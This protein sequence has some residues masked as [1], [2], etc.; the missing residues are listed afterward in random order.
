L[1]VSCPVHGYSGLGTIKE[2]NQLTFSCPM[3]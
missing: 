2:L 3:T 1:L